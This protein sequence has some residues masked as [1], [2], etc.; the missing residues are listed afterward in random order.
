MGMEKAVPLPQGIPTW[1][2]VVAELQRRGISVHMRMIDGELAF[3]EESPPDS[4]RE[5]R[6]AHQGSM[7]T[8]RR[9]DNAVI[10]VTWG[11]PDPGQLQ[12]A[13]A[14]TEAFASTQNP[15]VPPPSAG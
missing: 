1:P 3:P 2:S 6:V 11:N 5:L 13:E 7:V 14:L 8:I 12:L 9:G 4:W 10:L 15:G